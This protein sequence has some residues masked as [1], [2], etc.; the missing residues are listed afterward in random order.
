M[1][2]FIRDFFSRAH[3]WAKDYFSRLWQ[4]LRRGAFERLDFRYAD[5]LEPALLLGDD[6]DFADDGLVGRFLRYQRRR[7]WG[8]GEL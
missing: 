4:K 5:Y 8:F 7:E 6:Y 2:T 3:G 1:F